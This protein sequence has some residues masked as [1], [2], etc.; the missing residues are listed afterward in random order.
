MK[1]PNYDE[2]N[3]IFTIKDSSIIMPGCYFFTSYF[4][5]KVYYSVCIDQRKRI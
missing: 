3:V 2:K 1:L 4:L 5:P